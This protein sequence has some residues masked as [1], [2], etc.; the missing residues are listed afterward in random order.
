M[1]L[2]EQESQE[3][4]QKL[5]TFFKEYQQLL[6]S[7]T[8]DKPRAMKDAELIPV[9]TKTDLIYYFEL[10]LTLKEFNEW[11]ENNERLKEKVNDFI[12]NN[13]VH[14]AASFKMKELMQEYKDANVQFEQL[15]IRVNFNN[16]Q[17]LTDHNK[18]YEK[19]SLG[20]DEPSDVS[21]VEK[22]KILS[23]VEKYN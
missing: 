2:T 4:E 3:L 7:G 20:M 10:D 17:T 23:T 1:I 19:V 6:W 21:D 14:Y 13:Y 11:L 16:M 12:N 9:I 8:K 18:K 5:L 22:E 15:E